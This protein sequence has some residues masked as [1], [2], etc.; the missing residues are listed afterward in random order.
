MTFL[1]AAYAATWVIHIV[2]LGTVLSRYTKVRK[3]FDE[4]KRKKI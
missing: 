1:Y 2:Y 4:L 3:E